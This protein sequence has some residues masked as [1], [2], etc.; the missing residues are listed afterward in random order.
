LQLTKC[1][2]VSQMS[3]SPFLRGLG[4]KKTF[5]WREKMRAMIKRPG[6]EDTPLKIGGLDV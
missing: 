3:C 4:L 1:L 5:P 2:F 6:E